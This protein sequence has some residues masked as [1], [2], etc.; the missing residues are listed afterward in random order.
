MLEQVALRTTDGTRRMLVGSR[1]R[2]DGSNLGDG[3]P[4]PTF[5]D[6]TEMRSGIAPMPVMRAACSGARKR[7]LIYTAKAWLE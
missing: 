4:N 7:P 5:R 1:G 3:A 2:V 6:R